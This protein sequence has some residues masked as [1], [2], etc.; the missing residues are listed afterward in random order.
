AA[1]STAGSSGTACS[2]REPSRRRRLRWEHQLVLIALVGGLPALTLGTV[3][4]ARVDMDPSLRGLALVALWLVWVVST[5]IVV[6]RSVRPM[7]T[8]SNMVAAIR[9]GDT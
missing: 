8:L 7:Q 2:V 1:R 5:G 3:F 4:L 6:E 9:E